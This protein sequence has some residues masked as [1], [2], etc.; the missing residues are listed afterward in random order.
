MKIYAHWKYRIIG[1][2]SSC[3]TFRQL[4]YC[5]LSSCI[6]SSCQQFM[7]AVVLHTFPTH[8]AVSIFTVS[9]LVAV[10]HCGSVSIFIIIS[11]IEYCFMCSSIILIFS[12]IKYLFKLLPILNWAVCFLS[13]FWEN[14]YIL[15]ASLYQTLKVTN[16]SC[17]SV[18]CLSFF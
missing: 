12:L 8:C 2:W 15:D 11:D 5:V 1:S 17:Q 3:K 16:I 9:I 10:F 4:P 6:M 13:E 18:V 7:R 14:L